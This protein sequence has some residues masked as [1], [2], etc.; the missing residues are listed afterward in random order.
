MEGY[1]ISF[2]VF[3]KDQDEADRT[4]LLIRKFVDDY[5]RKGI[6]VT[7]GKIAAAVTKY[8]DSFVLTSYFK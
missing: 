8:K 2:K 3:A 1:E 4:A 6:A 7:A 5:A